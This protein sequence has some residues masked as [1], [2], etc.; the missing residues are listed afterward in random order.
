MRSS[1]EMALPDHSFALRLGTAAFLPSD[2]PLFSQSKLMI[3]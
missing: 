1:P 3:F 2:C